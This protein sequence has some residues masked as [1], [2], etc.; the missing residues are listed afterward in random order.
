[1]LVKITVATR[2]ADF[3]V[4]DVNLPPCQCYEIFRGF[5]HAPLL[6]QI[7]F[8]GAFGFTALSLVVGGICLALGLVGKGQRSTRR[9]GVAGAIGRLL[10]WGSGYYLA[11]WLSTSY[12]NGAVD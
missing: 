8:L 9:I 4:A 10:V 6:A 2:G 11:W 7:S 3:P 5:R 1:M 12:P